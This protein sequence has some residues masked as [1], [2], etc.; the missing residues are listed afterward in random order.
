MHPE[1]VFRV[2]KA[3][4][5]CPREAQESQGALRVGSFPEERLREPGLQVAGGCRE[6][7]WMLHLSEHLLFQ[8]KLLRQFSPGGRLGL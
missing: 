4:L 7:D 6:P 5:R 1:S 2:P 3:A 8:G